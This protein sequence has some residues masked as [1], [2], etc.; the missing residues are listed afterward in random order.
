[1]FFELVYA[2]ELQSFYQDHI[3]S[4]S[5]NITLPVFFILSY[6]NFNI[7]IHANS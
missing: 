3:K 7:F 5:Y 6:Q 1:M 4:P 2:T